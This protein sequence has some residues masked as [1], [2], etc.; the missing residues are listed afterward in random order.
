MKKKVLSLSITAAFGEW[1]EGPWTI[2]PY[3]FGVKYEVP[4]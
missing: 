4:R 2:Y 3:V 1:V